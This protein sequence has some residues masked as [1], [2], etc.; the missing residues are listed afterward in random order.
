[1][2]ENRGKERDTEERSK[3]TKNCVKVKRGRRTTDG[4]KR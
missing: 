2:E 3:N 1:M 4:T